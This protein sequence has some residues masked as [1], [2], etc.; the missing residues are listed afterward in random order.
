MAQGMRSLSVSDR[1]GM[2][3]IYK[4]MKKEEFISQI[5]KLVSFETV[6]GNVAE[7]SE[8]LSYVESL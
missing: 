4:L 3:K 5:A 6:T 8:A 1:I 7:N 2:V